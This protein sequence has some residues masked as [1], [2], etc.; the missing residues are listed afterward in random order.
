MPRSRWHRGILG[1]TDH[2]LLL[3]Q[4]PGRP[5]RH[6]AVGKSKR[7]TRHD[8]LYWECPL[9]PRYWQ[10][11]AS[12]G[13]RYGGQASGAGFFALTSSEEKASWL[14]T[15]PE[16]QPRSRMHRLFAWLPMARGQELSAYGIT[17]PPSRRCPAEW[18]QRKRDFLAAGSRKGTTPRGNRRKLQTGFHRTCLSV[19]DTSHHPPSQCVSWGGLVHIEMCTH[20]VPYAQTPSSFVVID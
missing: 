19:S 3:R 8:L 11:A 20:D 14:P 10:P 4:P 9:K 12:L 18:V 17:T 7:E 16:R 13:R 15:M 2:N 5:R 6:A 1:V